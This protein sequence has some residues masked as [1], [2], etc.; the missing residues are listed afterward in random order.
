MY[1][2]VEIAGQQF[3]V[4]KE[5]EIFVHRLEGEKGSSVEFGNVLL[6]DNN[7]KV[8]VGMP[9]VKGAVIQAKIIEHLRGDKVMVFHKKRRKGYQKEN[10]HRQYLSK[11]LIEEILTSGSKAEKKDEVKNEEAKPRKK[12]V[13]KPEA[14]ELKSVAAASIETETTSKKTAVKDSEAKAEEMKKE[15]TGVSD[16]SKT[17]AEVKETKTR[18]KKE[19]ASENT[20]SPDSESSAMTDTD[21]KEEI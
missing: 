2:I 17:G 9:L 6:L 1:A 16:E 18:A 21:K 15:I 19:V 12:T 7:G 14:D 4:E 8:T 13:E 11:I 5:Q 20:E 3:K 10:G